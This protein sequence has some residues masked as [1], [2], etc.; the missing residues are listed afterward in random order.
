MAA[1][2]MQ[3]RNL[4]H[5]LLIAQK[6][7]FPNTHLKQPSCTPS[8]SDTGYNKDVASRRNKP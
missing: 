5:R 2:S 3:G 6:T 7:L 1:Q 8:S 4:F